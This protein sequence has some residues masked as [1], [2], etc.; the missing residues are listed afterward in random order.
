M[1]SKTRSSLEYLCFLLIEGVFVYAG[2]EHIGERYNIDSSTVRRY[3]CEL[4]KQ[5]VI[6][7][8]WRPSVKL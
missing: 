4:E 1:K 5:G 3:L 7:R 6:K 2:S 8:K